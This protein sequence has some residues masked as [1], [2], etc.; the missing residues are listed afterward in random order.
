MSAAEKQQ[1]DDDAVAAAAVARGAEAAGDVMAAGADSDMEDEGQDK[2]GPSAAGAPWDTSG[3]GAPWDTS[4]E[5]DPDTGKATAS[6]ILTLR[7]HLKTIMFLLSFSELACW[8][9]AGGTGSRWSVWEEST[10]SRAQLVFGMDCCAIARMV[11]GRSCREVAARL[12]ALRAGGQAIGE[13]STRNVQLGRKRQWRKVGVG[14]APLRS[15][16]LE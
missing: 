8:I 12:A 7:A 13:A 9:S 10:L 3:E 5:G 4:G 16:P 1:Q 15:A 11:E 14:H 6:L 2:A